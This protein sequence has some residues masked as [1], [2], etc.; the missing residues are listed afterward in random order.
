VPVGGILGILKFLQL[1]F[2]VLLAFDDSDHAGGT[3]GADIMPNDG[4][5]SGEF[6]ACQKESI[7]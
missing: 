3:V 2:G 6:V 4:V 7:S 1:Q 5:R